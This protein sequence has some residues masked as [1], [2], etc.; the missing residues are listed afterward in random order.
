MTVPYAGIPR[1]A[2]TA[3]IPV[4][5]HTPALRDGDTGPMGDNTGFKPLKIGREHFHDIRN[6]HETVRA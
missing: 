4:L 6:V 2:I 5:S 3:Y 1:N